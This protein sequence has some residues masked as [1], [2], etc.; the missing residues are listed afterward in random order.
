M[1]TS[2]KLNRNSK[3]MLGILAALSVWSFQVT[4]Q[5]KARKAKAAVERVAAGQQAALAPALPTPIR[6]IA[7]A[8]L[9]SL[10]LA[11]WGQD[12]Y[13]KT[14]SFLPQPGAD[15][16]VLP[17]LHRPARPT[18]EGLVL[19][20]ILWAGEHSSAQIG[21]HVSQVGEMVNGW[22]IVEIKQSSVIL[23]NH[24]V[25]ITLQLHEGQS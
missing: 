2:M 16:A 18:G 10:Q 17:R 7:A 4:Q 19:R 12:P 5:T 6:P 13:F 24:G 23:T 9:A 21:D 3:I 11:P 8:S 20:G 25:T 22:K 1:N 15:A 14:E